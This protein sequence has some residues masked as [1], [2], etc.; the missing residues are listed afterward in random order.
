MSKRQKAHKLII[1]NYI[2]IRHKNANLR[3]SVACIRGQLFRIE[4]MLDGE[5]CCSHHWRPASLSRTDGG[6]LLM[7]NVYHHCS[8]K[9][10]VVGL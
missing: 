6:Q 7:H 1:R 9:Q 3:N 8:R 4:P 10:N 5:G 2:S